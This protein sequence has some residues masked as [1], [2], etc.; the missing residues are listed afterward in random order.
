MDRNRKYAT[1]PGRF[2]R[3]VI[4]LDMSEL[5]GPGVSTIVHNGPFNTIGGCDGCVDL[6]NPDNKG[7]EE[8]IT[9]IADI[10][11][12]FKETHSRADIWA[13]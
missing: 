3:Q 8:P 7:L 2:A 6:A 10:F 12:R 13:Q 5:S 9:E 11:D 1:L 4:C